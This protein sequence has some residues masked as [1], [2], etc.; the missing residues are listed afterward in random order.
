MREFANGIDDSKVEDTYDD[1]KWIWASSITV[2]DTKDRDYILTFLEW[3][4]TEL[5]YELRDRKKVWDIIHVHIR[6]STFKMK[7]HQMKYSSWVN[8]FKEIYPIAVKLFDELWD[9]SEINLVW[10]SVSWLKDEKV[11]QKPI[12]IF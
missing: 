5:A 7:S 3:F 2:V 8:R 4:A 11:K 10:L 9:W 1:R 6:Y 12:F